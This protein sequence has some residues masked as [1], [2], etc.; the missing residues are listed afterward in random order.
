MKK[1]ALLSMGI[2][3]TVMIVFL[4]SCNQ[5]E[6]EEPHDTGSDT[7]TTDPAAARLTVPAENYSV[8]GPRKLGEFDKTSVAAVRN[9]LKKVSGADVVSYE[10]AVAGTENADQYEVIVGNTGRKES[11]A[12]LSKLGFNQYGFT[13]TEKKIIIAGWTSQTTRAAIQF[14]NNT[15]NGLIK[16]NAEGKKYFDFRI[17]ENQ[18]KDYDNYLD[19]FPQWSG[20]IKGVYDSSDGAFTVVYSGV[21]S[22]DF[23]AYTATVTNAGFTALIENTLGN[24][25]YA[26]Y[27]NGDRQVHFYYVD[28]KQE[29]RVVL[30]AKDVVASLLQTEVTGTVTPSVTQMNMKYL[31]ASGGGACTI[32]TL[33]DGTFLVI[34]GGWADEASLLYSTLAALNEDAN[35]KGAPIVISAWFLTHGHGDHIGCIYQ[36]A[37]EFGDKVKVNAVL[38]ND[39]DEAQMMDTTHTTDVLSCKKLQSRVLSHMTD[40][41]GNKPALMKLHTGQKLTFG[42]AQLDV[43]FTHEDLFGTALKNFN[44]LCTIVKVTL[45]GNRFFMTADAS[46]VELPAL[47]AEL[48]SSVLESEFCQMG[49]H[50]AD[51]GYKPLYEAVK[52]KYIL[53]PNSEK[54]Y[55]RDMSNSKYDWCQ[56]IK[57]HHDELY[58][59]DTYCYTFMLPYTPE[60]AIKWNASIEKPSDAAAGSQ[61]PSSGST[62]YGDTI[63]WTDGTG[64]GDTASWTEDIAQ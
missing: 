44:D 20:K 8:V 31:Q 59:A 13:V 47:L 32:F 64:Y 53:Y 63:P 14:F 62:G 41:N 24:N 12:F 6:Q 49:H 45:G 48:P 2:L 46:N 42:G 33:Q 4:G 38:C 40:V 7:S 21:T 15:A 11:D 18:V 28:G 9:Y 60:S 58:L 54:D 36:F 30:G 26:T 39:V 51:R 5:V 17:G 27:A 55:N 35:G 10:D 50:G 43:L 37:T 56:Y 16:E 19:G 34:D 25:R 3:L 52:A 22:A 1:I 61:N 29:M 23:D 57:E